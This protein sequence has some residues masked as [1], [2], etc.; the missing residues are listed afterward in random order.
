M[1]GDGLRVDLSNVQ[2]RETKAVEGREGNRV[3]S[4]SC[5]CAPE[6]RDSAS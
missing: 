1:R 4:H 5:A 6:E 2:R 3:L